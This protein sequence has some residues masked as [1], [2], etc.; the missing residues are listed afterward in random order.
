MY[1]GFVW[2]F[3]VC[4][5]LFSV[6]GV[7]GSLIPSS[8]SGSKELLVWTLYLIVLSWL[9]SA[10]GL[11]SFWLLSDSLLDQALLARPLVV[12]RNLASGLSCIFSKLIFLLVLV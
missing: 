9:F 12:C 1:I 4:W 5:V 10:R 2:G 6:V 7:S 3:L 8:F 11:S